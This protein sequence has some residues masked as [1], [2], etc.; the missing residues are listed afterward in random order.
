MM[1]EEHGIGI[2]FL[3]SE[4]AA[5]TFDFYGFCVVFVV[6]SAIRDLDS[7]LCEGLK[8]HLY[9]YISLGH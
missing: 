5:Q 3:W 2:V 6:G 9:I 4:L 7:L 1:H 8:L